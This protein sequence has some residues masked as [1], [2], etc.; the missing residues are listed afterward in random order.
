MDINIVV[1]QTINEITMNIYNIFY[2]CI[3]TISFLSILS[4]LSIGFIV[5]ITFAQAL[6][7]NPLILFALMVIFAISNEKLQLVKQLDNIIR[8][9]DNSKSKRCV[10]S[11]VA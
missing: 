9:P 2:H 6:V 3:R 7:I 11:K 10:L 5:P 8:L 1:I 4:I